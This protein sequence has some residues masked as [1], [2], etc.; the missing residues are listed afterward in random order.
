[1]N[2]ILFISNLNKS[3]KLNEKIPLPSGHDLLTHA[4][5]RRAKTQQNGRH[6]TPGT[7]SSASGTKIASGTAPKTSASTLT[8]REIW[9]C[10]TNRRV[11]L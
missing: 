2:I 3:K 7:H 11:P 8:L 4:L 9:P 10:L 1:M 5:T 6:P